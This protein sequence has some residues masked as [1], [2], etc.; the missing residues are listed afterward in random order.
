MTK[1]LGYHHS[2]QHILSEIPNLTFKKIQHHLREKKITEEDKDRSG[3]AFLDPTVSGLNT[4][5]KGD[6]LQKK[7]QQ[8]LD[9]T[10][11]SE[12]SHGE[13]DIDYE[14]ADV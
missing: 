3:P 6:W 7:L 10:L 2:Q 9:D 1:S 12:Q 14:L 8:S 13:I 11:Q 4:L 5:S